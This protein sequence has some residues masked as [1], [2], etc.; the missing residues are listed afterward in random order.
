MLRAASRLAASGVVAVSGAALAS[1][2]LDCEGDAAAQMYGNILM[3]ALRYI[4]DGEQAHRAAILAAKMGLTP[5][6]RTEDPPVLRTELFGRAVCNPIGLAAGFDKDGEAVAGLFGGGFGMVEIGSVT[7]KPQPGNPK[8]RVFRLPEDGAVINRY[9]FNS[10]GHDESKAHLTAFRQ[11]SASQVASAK[12][13]LLGINLG[14]NKTSEDADADYCAGVRALGS[15]ADYLVVNVSSP[16]TPGLRNLQQRTQLASLLKAVLKER[17]AMPADANGKRPPL[18]LKVAP[19]L[20]ASQMD[21]I[22]AVALQEKVDGLIV[23]NTTISREGLTGAAKGETGGLS[24]KPL[25]EKSTQVLGELYQRTGGKVTIIGVGGVSCGK[26][27]YAKIRAGASAVQLY[28][29]LVYGGPPL[30]PKVKRELAELLKADGYAC[31]TDAVGADHKS[32]KATTSRWF[33]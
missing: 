24:G 4:L 3:P 26:D 6:Q 5:K 12:G 19:D 14:K 7:P 25:L 29:S 11:S 1:S 21:D 15:L 33:K 13:Q 27:A 18:L 22:A 10:C 30:V 20:T 2:Q 23:S 17:D 32:S 8:P 16:N 31:V 9:G 28:T